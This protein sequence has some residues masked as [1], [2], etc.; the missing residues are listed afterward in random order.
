MSE[1]DGKRRRPSLRWRLFAILTVPI[2]AM[3]L[4]SAAFIYGSV[5]NY[6]RTEHDRGLVTNARS[7]AALIANGLEIGTLSPQV[8]YL[9]AYDSEGSTY[10]SVQ[11]QRHGILSSTDTYPTPPRLPAIDAE[12]LLFD[13]VVDGRP[14]RAV[15]L[16]FRPPT[17]SDDVITVTMAETLHSRQRLAREILLLTLLLQGLLIAGLLALCLL[18]TSPSPRDS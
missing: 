8:R 14:V 16:V 17:E 10:F 6:D 7:V 13:S 4:L 5:L 2:F 11:S 15:C 3:L 1:P 12:P 18:Y 9:L